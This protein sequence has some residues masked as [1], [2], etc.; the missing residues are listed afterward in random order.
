MAYLEIKHLSKSFDRKNVLSDINISLDKGKTLCLIGDSGSGKTTFLRIL[1]FLEKKDNGIIL[2]D[3]KTILGDAKLS[4]KEILQR[5]MD[6]GL[7]FQ[8]FNLFPQYTV[9]ENV[10][11]PLR[12]QLWRKFKSE[13]KLLPRKGRGQAKKALSARLLNKARQEV[14]N[15]L[16][17]VNPLEKKDN[18][19]GQ[20]S[21]GEAQRTA[22]VRALILKPK[23]ICF[24]EPT[25]ALDPKLKNEVAQAILA[26]KKNGT[27]MIVVTHEMELAKKVSDQL[28]F[29]EKGKIVE[30][31]EPTILYQPQPQALK[32]FLSLERK[33]S[34][35]RGEETT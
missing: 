1:N 29:I 20:L 22:I 31:G 17:S 8:N 21:G 6:F 14:A 12:I 26:L 35:G 24:D 30:E 19:P 33:N 3:G 28:A 34:D 23:I 13:V 25:S 11:L 4:N 18:Y 27:T 7:V 2:L 5:R 16:K 32:D 9:F 15:L 10:L